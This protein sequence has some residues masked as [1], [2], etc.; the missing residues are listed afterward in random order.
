[1]ILHLLE[2]QKYLLSSPC[3]Q[4]CLCILSSNENA[5]TA[6]GFGEFILPLYVTE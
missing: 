5:N 6:V 3:S 2:G 4:P 1:M